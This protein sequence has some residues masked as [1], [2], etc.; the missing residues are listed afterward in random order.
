MMGPSSF[1]VGPSS[2]GHT[3]AWVFTLGIETESK[4]KKVPVLA[5]TLATLL[6]K[7]DV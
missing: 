6:G 5:E 1:L 4:Q 2:R 3:D 7:F